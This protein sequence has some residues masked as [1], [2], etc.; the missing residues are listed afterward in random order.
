MAK[1]RKEKKMIKKP[2][3]E[4]GRKG[5]NAFVKEHLR[6]PEE[7]LQKGIEGTVVLKLFINYLGTVTNVKI[8]AGIGAGCDE[9]AARVAKMMEFQ[10]DKVYKVKVKYQKSLNIHFKLPKKV[11]QETQKYAYKYKPVEDSNTEKSY[12]YTITL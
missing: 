7:A 9:E 2:V 10:V 12:S 5:F 8:I 3:F 4:G 6:Y 1:E 11:Q